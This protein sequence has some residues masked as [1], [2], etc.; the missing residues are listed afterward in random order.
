MLLILPVISYDLPSKLSKQGLLVISAR[1]GYKLLYKSWYWY[2]H[3]MT[4]NG[5]ISV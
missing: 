3:K 2:C 1:E 4:I 5:N